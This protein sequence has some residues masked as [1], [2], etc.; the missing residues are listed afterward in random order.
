MSKTGAETLD[1]R[2]LI[3]EA[4]AIEGIGPEDCRS[5]FFDWAMGLAPGLDPGD[6]ARQLAEAY[7]AP[8]GHPMTALLEE[9]Q[10]QAEGGRPSRRRG[11]GRRLN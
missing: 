10:R 11:R 1:P 5:I 8:G 4:F 2:G 9:A 6:A 3:R 7:G